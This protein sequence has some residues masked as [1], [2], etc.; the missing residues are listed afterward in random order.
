MSGYF[1]RYLHK[2]IYLPSVS[3]I[4]MIMNSLKYLPVLGIFVLSSCTF[5]GQKPQASVPTPP[6]TSLTGNIIGNEP[7]ILTGAIQTPPA[8][9]IVEAGKT[10][11][12]PLVLVDG[13]SSLKIQS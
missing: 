12:I 2:S 8:M 4:F 9:V 13:K 11:Y 1:F 7:P 5:P 6:A 10:K 3:L